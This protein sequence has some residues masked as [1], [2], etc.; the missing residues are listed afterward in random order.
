MEQTAQKC[1][2]VSFSGDIQDFLGHF[3]MEPPVRNLAGRFGFNDS[4]EKI[5][6]GRLSRDNDGRDLPTYMIL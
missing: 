6:K 5:S 3:L 1:Y 2:G 4:K